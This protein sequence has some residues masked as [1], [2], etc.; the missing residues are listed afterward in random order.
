MSRMGPDRVADIS[1]GFVGRPPAAPK[2][3][4]LAPTVNVS[5]SGIVTF[6]WSG[7]I[8]PE[9]LERAVRAAAETRWLAAVSVASRYLCPLKIWLLGGQC[10]AGRLPAGGDSPRGDRTA[11]RFVRGH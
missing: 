11:R 8:S 6:D 1:I 2:V 3:T 7:S 4:D 10:C 5:D 9:L